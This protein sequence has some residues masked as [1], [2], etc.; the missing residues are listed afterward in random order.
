[1][2]SQILALLAAV[3]VASAAPQMA[4]RST[5]TSSDRFG[6]IA[7]RSGSDVHLQSFQASQSQIFIGLADQNAT[8]D[9]E[10]EF[11]SFS[12]S[13][14]GSLNLYSTD[15]P[16]QTAYVDASGM[17]QGVFGY[18]TGAEPTPTNA[19]KTAFTLDANNDL[20]FNNATFLACPY[21]NGSYSVWVNA[22][23]ANP[24]GNTD[25]L[26]IVVRATVLDNPVSCTYS[27]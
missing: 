24:G 8:C 21:T 15:A 1:M 3:G 4:P 22:G 17:G 9:T 14:D 11:A 16:F 12:L 2:Q 5:I 10:S 26:G 25:C 13:D 20:T 19:Q 7:I 18:V 27:Q 6:L 23:V